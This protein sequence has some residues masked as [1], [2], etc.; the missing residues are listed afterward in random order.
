MTAA[1]VALAPQADG[2]EGTLHVQ[3]GEA[4]ECYAASNPVINPASQRMRKERKV[5]GTNKV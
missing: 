5:E 3:I 4:Q 2:E 1:Y